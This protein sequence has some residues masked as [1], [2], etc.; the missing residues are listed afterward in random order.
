MAFNEIYM[1]AA[2]VERIDGSNIKQ[3]FQK[4]APLLN[5]RQQLYTYYEREQQT[6]DNINN[7]ASALVFSP[8][9]R[10]ATNIAAG[11]FIGKPCK[12]YSRVTT[13]VRTVEMLNGQ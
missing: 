3:V 9:A 5:L 7:P 2:D 6:I 11:Y 1:S 13:T 8:I 12:Y 10:Y 4:F